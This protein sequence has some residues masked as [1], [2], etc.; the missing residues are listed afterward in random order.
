[1]GLTYCCVKKQ[2]GPDNLCNDFKQLKLHKNGLII[3]GR[4]K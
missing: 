1:M 4:A 2:K 3:D